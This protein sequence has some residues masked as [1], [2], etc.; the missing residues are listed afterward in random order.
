MNITWDQ[1]VAQSAAM[2]FFAL[3]FVAS[4]TAAWHRII[5]SHRRDTTY[6]VMRVG[7][8]SL[9]FLLAAL[10]GWTGNGRFLPVG[11]VVQHGMSL[12]IVSFIMLDIR[13]RVPEYLLRCSFFLGAWLLSH[14][15][16]GLPQWYLLTT[17]GIAFWMWSMWHYGARIRY[18]VVTHTLAFIAIGVIYWMTMPSMGIWYKATATIMV[19]ATVVY[20]FA[21]IAT[22]VYLLRM[23]RAEHKLAATV[24][25]AGYDAL[26]NT[27]NFANFTRDLA[28]IYTAARRENHSF[29]LVTFDIDH[30]KQVNDQY[31]HPAGNTVLVGVAQMM[32]AT[33]DRSRLTG[34]LYR[35][36]GEEF[37]LLFPNDSAAK[38]LPLVEAL[39]KRLRVTSFRTGD[40]VIKITLS[41]G[42]TDLRGDDVSGDT[43]YKRA[44]TY[45][46]QS[47]Q[48]GRDRITVNGITR[49]EQAA[50]KMQALYAYYTQNIV[51]LQLDGAVK[52][53]ELILAHYDQQEMRWR[54]ETHLIP[55][56]SQ[57]PFMRQVVAAAPRTRLAINLDV[58]ESTTPQTLALLHDFMTG[59]PKPHGLMVELQLPI[60]TERLAAIRELY[61]PDDIRVVV[62]VTTVSNSAKNL[63]P[64]LPLVDGIKLPL[65]ELR[66]AFSDTQFEAAAAAWY[67][68]CREASVDIIFT[69]IETSRDAAYVRDEL[70]ARYVQGFVYDR[71]D[72][73]RLD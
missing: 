37:C 56:E 40:E 7:L 64:L 13:L 6:W 16:F 51:D 27:R 11:S 38:V 1:M 67:R 29:S 69:G 73:P 63:T 46:Y 25:A 28:A 26:T 58:H 54:E 31:G 48:R 68:Q 15:G 3:G 12:F 70:H 59:T 39:H 8:P 36:G 20:A 55:L 52:A 49:G 5:Q 71:P 62:E 61:R 14:N 21:A 17:V 50:V 43:L 34:K 19:Q 23:Q 33:L 65:P 44:D 24:H 53:S 57:L 30:F 22:A 10:F 66:A 9:A 4:Y 32:Q 45:L 60:S 18:H 2:L 42:M 47:K 35:T 72:L 41:C